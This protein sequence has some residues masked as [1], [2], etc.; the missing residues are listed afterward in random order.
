M[1]SIRINERR[2]RMSFNVFIMVLFIWF[3]LIVVAAMRADGPIAAKV[4][5]LAAMGAGD[6]YF[7]IA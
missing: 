6:P 7:M 5:L 4:E 2:L 1:S 3:F